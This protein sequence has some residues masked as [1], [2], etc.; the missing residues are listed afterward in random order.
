MREDDAGIHG[1]MRMENDGP[2]RVVLTERRIA[3]RRPTFAAGSE[4][5]LDRGIRHD[6]D[7]HSP[8]WISRFTDMTRQAAA[9]RDRRVLLAGDA[10]HV[11]PPVGGQGLN[12]GVQD[13]VNLGWK[14]A[15]VVQGRSPDKLARYVSRRAPSGRRARACRTRWRRWRCVVRTI[16]ARHWRP[17]WIASC[18]ATTRDGNSPRRCPASACITTSAKGIPC[19]GVACPTWTWSPTKD[20]FASIRCGMTRRRCCST[21]DRHRSTSRLGR[22]A[23]GRSMLRLQARGK[24]PALGAVA[25]PEAVLIRPDGYVVWV[26]EGRHR[27]AGGATEWCGA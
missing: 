3:I 4:R 12:I 25:A 6:F 20:R 16:G 1:L 27:I 14:L 26:G 18:K 2:I 23:F 24:L 15:Q 8:T 9:Y 11:H 19:S 10:A 7:V 17:R 13:A 21:S 22:I 5:S